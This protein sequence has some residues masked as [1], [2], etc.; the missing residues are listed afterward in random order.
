MYVAFGTVSE[1]KPEV[2]PVDVCNTHQARHNSLS[3][4]I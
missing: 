1:K 2:K 3:L 4:S